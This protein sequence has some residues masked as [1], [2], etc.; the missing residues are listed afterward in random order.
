MHTVRLSDRGVVPCVAAEEDQQAHKL[1]V[2]A[3]G[4]KLSIFDCPKLPV[5]GAI[6]AFSA[7][8][9]HSKAV[10]DLGLANLPDR[11]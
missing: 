10:A 2:A 3:R 6:P 7:G 9:L 4:R 1:H 8:R 11:P 5:C